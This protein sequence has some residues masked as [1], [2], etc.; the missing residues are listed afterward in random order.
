VLSALLASEALASGYKS[1]RFQ[2]EEATIEDIHEAIRARR[3]TATQLVHLYLERIKAYNGTCVNEPEGIL[4]PISTIP[5]AGKLNALITL[6][7]R[8][9]A[10]V[11]WGFDARKARSMTDPIDDDPGMP[12]ALEVAAELDRKFART[13]KL[14]GP[15]HGVVIAIRTSTTPSTCARPRARTP[16]GP[17]T[18]RPTTPPSCRGCAMQARS[19]WPRRTWAST[20][21]AAS[22]G[23]AARSAG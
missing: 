18:A 3:L 12:D 15:L 13:R 2:V 11:A 5:H 8:P 19:S 7:L 14:V 23:R 10:R 6:N 17:T 1:R 9:A 4:G 16:S 22:P 21:P 20:P